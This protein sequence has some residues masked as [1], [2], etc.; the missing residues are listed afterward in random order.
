MFRKVSSRFII[1]FFIKVYDIFIIG[2]INI[3]KECQFCKSGCTSCTL[4]D[5]CTSL[6]NTEKCIDGYFYNVE[7]QLC[8]K[9]KTGCATC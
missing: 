1:G 5:N 6:N 2:Y 4:E 7:E 3:G 9:C 8:K